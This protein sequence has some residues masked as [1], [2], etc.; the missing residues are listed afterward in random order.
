MKYVKILLLL[1]LFLISKNAEAQ[2][3]MKSKIAKLGYSSDFILKKEK[4]L[5]Q[6]KTIQAN[7]KA[8]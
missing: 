2:I 5:H 4:K 1:P 3:V 7:Q 8:D 6:N